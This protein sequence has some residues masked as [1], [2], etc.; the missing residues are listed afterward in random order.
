VT[1]AR[2]PGDE[3]FGDDRLI[4]RIVANAARPPLELM[5]S[6]FEAVHDFCQGTDQGDDITVTVSRFDSPRST[7]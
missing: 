6:V 2:N 7:S 4:E 3:E 5:R 1:E